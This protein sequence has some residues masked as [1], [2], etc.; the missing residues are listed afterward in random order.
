MEHLVSHITRNYRL[1]SNVIGGCY[2]FVAHN[3]VIVKDW[4]L[5][6]YFEALSGIST[7][8]FV[9]HTFDGGTLIIDKTTGYMAMHIMI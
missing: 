4:V 8:S 3:D 6:I 2:T 5:S 7:R 1:V 9:K